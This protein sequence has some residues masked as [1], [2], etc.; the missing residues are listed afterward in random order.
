MGAARFFVVE[1][2]VEVNGWK[3]L[4]VDYLLILTSLRCYRLGIFVIATSEKRP[5]AGYT[6]MYACLGGTLRLG[7]RGALRSYRQ[8]TFD[9]WTEYVEKAMTVRRIAPPGTQ[10]Y[11]RA[12]SAYI[13][14]V[15]TCGATTT[16]D[17]NFQF[18]TEF[19]P[20]S[21]APGWIC[22]VRKR[23]LGQLSAA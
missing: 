3:A 7:E 1:V 13:L 8:P 22:L 16:F 10:R 2:K 12:R 15:V 5:T 11:I 19:P 20:Y 4:Q 17:R 9:A 23:R 6:C 18:D 21:R 14:R